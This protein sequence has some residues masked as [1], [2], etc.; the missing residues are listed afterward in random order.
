MEGYERATANDLTAIM[1]SINRLTETRIAESQARTLLLTAQREGLRGVAN[2]VS[3]TAGMTNNAVSTPVLVAPT[4]IMKSNQEA[5]PDDDDAPPASLLQRLFSGGS[6][7]KKKKSKRRR[8]S[9]G[10][11]LVRVKTDEPTEEEY[12]VVDKEV[13][14]VVYDREVYNQ[15]KRKMDEDFLEDFTK[16]FVTTSEDIIVRQVLFLANARHLLRDID[17]AVLRKANQAAWPKEKQ[18]YVN[19]SPV[20]RQIKKRLARSYDEVA[21]KGVVEDRANG[22]AEGASAANAM[23]MEA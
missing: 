11:T 13:E 2:N 12:K 7:D 6:A 17:L 15:W 19:L 16:A 18:Y 3:P 4:S 22:A 21:A 9:F 8:I 1:P 20:R 14:V 23:E 5:T 10:S